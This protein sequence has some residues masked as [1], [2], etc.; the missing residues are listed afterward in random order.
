MKKFLFTLLS[1]AVFSQTATAE[2]V[3]L[4]YSSFL[5]ATTQT[6]NVTIPRLKTKLEKLSGGNLTVGTYF[7]GTLG[8]GPKT[9][10]RL[11]KNGVADFA[12]VPIPYTPGR[13]KGINVFEL[14]FVVKNNLNGSLKTLDLI[15]NNLITGTKRFVVLGA[16]QAGPYLIHTRDKITS[17]DDLKGKRMR[18]S[19]AIQSAIIKEFGAI[20]V[21]N[22]PATQIAENLSRKLLDGALVDMGNVYNFRIEEE[23]KYHVTN[24]HL[25]AFSVL[26]LMNKD[27][28]NSLSADNKK[29]IDAIKGEWF[30]KELGK[31]MDIQA[32]MVLN[33]LKAD[34]SQHLIALPEADVAK[35]HKKMKKVIDDWTKQ[36][37]RNA[38][39]YQAATA[40]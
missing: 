16:L 35:A 2:Q 38:E 12:E 32:T 29:A 5:P 3:T 9:Q 25:G 4:K 1:V 23:T 27:K 33:K 30:T 10:M 37:T 36:N 15:D 40:E 22:I 21:A 18:V 31:E 24:L 8:A 39:V 7:G 20:P 14:P 11:V 26:F 17:I 28:Y 13:V 34:D 19:G 6:N